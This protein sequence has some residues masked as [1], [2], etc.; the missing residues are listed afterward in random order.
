MSTARTVFINGRFLSQRVTGVQRYAREVLAA[1][2]DL[3]T[4]AGSSFPLALEVLAPPGT[5]DPGLRS[6]GFRCVGPLRGNAWE[7]LT[8]PLAT[9]GR[10]LYGF[11][12]T[13][14][15]AKLDQVITIH[16]AA[17]YS[18]PQ[19]Y[20][21]RFRLWYKLLLGFL[22]QRVP[23]VVTVSQF[24]RAEIVRH[25]G[26]D[27]SKI[28][29]TVE[30]WQHLARIAPDPSILPRH[31]LRPRRYVLAV[32][33]PTPSKNFIQIARAVALLDAP[34][35][36]VVVAG[37]RDRGVFGAAAL[38]DAPFIKYV[39]YVSD[40]ELRSLYEHAGVF[41]Y[42]SLYEGF[43]IP[44]IEA[45]A[46]HCPVIASNAASLP[47]VC[48]D[49]AVLVSPH[50][51]AALAAAIVG[52]MASSAERERLAQNGALRLRHFSWEA[53]AKT[54]LDCMLECAGSL[55]PEAQAA[56]A[57]LAMTPAEE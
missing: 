33:S 49:A 45:M 48:G 6:I 16:D 23:R 21:W 7:Q 55:T 15:A 27:P 12:A 36:D 9:R 22:A 51:P 18:V 54:V 20:N 41:V 14:P 46:S 11:S 39:G 28:R 13:G 5:P 10:L 42:P 2:D 31:G 8:L 47:E 44:V 50:D 26:C 25:F 17:V 37:A 24:S 19:A 43:G 35:F 32:S 29:V 3:L 38:P 1:L 4:A 56:S 40:A 30:G 34:D 52:V 57:A 53:A